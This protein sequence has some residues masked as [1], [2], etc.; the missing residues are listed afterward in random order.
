MQKLKHVFDRMKTH[1]ICSFETDA[2]SARL[3]LL[4]EALVI[5]T[6]DRVNAIAIVKPIPKLTRV[7]R[8]PSP[9]VISIVSEISLIDDAALRRILHTETV[10][11]GSAHLTLVY[12]TIVQKNDAVPV[13]R[14]P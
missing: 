8:C 13:D 12:H 10:L 2:L 3:R 9:T 11:S 1:H 7:D 6:V 4:K 5:V 14:V